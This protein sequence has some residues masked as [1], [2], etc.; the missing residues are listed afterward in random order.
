MRNVLL[1]LRFGIRQMLKAPGFA[2][3]TILTIAQRTLEIGVRIWRSVLRAMVLAALGLA[4][5]IIASMALTSF[6]KGMLFGIRPL[7]AVTFVGVSAVLLLVCLLASSA[8]AYRAA[9]LDP[10]KTLRDQ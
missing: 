6:L 4:L 8:P 3:A 9:L 7:D 2:V 5:G 10:M 1:D